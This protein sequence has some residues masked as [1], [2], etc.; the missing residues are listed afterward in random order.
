[1]KINVYNLYITNLYV[2]DCYCDNYKKVK[3]HK[4][5]SV[6]IYMDR[7][8]NLFDLFTGKRYKKNIEMFGYDEKGSQFIVVNELT[9]L[10]NVMQFSD[11]KMSKGKLVKKIHTSFNRK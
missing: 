7:F 2:V 4:L 5:K 11:V 1:M 9:P 6:I 10:C 3:S 8:G